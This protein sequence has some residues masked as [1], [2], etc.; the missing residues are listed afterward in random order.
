MSRGKST[1]RAVRL[2]DTLDVA[3]MHACGGQDHFGEWARNIFRR[4]VGIKLGY[5]AGYEEGRR[6]GWT[7]ANAAFRAALDKVT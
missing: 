3:V 4:A 6:A 1:P 2:P 5:D 7:D